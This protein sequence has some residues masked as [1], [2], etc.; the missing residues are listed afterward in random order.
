MALPNPTLSAA[1]VGHMFHPA[2]GAPDP[3]AGFARR[4]DV[5]EIVRSHTLHRLAQSIGQRMADAAERHENTV[6]FGVADFPWA[7]PACLEEARRRLAQDLRY[8]ITNIESDVTGQSA[9]WRLSW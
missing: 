1:I 2:A 3:F 7:S 6:R 9:G 5:A 8:T 4:E